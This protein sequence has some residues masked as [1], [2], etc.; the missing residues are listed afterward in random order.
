MHLVLRLVVAD[1]HPQR[2]SQ[3]LCISSRKHRRVHDRHRA[4]W[5]ILLGP[6]RYHDLAAPAIPVRD[7]ELGTLV[8]KGLADLDELG[9]MVRGTRESAE[10]LL[11]LLLVLVCRGRELVER[12]RLVALEEVGHEY[13]GLQL[14]C[15]D[16]GAL[17]GL[18]LVPV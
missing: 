4:K 7:E 16:V 1:E 2:H 8:F 10:P 15:E 17:L 14:F 6:G 3:S 5:R 12:P 11:E 9:N 18:W 13:L